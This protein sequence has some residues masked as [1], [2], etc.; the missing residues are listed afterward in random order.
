[1]TQD[2]SANQDG[3]ASLGSSPEGEGVT[4][5]KYE[6][7][8]PDVTAE[9]KEQSAQEAIVF[10]NL[11]EAQDF[12]GK[13]PYNIVKSKLRSSNDVLKTATERGMVVKFER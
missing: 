1:V 3:I 9:V 2:V 11:S 8:T 4:E 12:F 7:S 6:A 5:T 13:E 10:R